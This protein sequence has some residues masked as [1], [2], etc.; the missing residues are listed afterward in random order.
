MTSTVSS[1][2][3][4]SF[5]SHDDFCRIVCIHLVEVWEPII[6]IPGHRDRPCLTGIAFVRH[7]RGHLH[8]T[9]RDNFRQRDEPSEI[10]F[11]PTCSKATRLLP[12]YSAYIVFVERRQGCTSGSTALQCIMMPRRTAQ[13]GMFSDICNARLSRITTLTQNVSHPRCAIGGIV[14]AQRMDDLDTFLRKLRR[15]K[16]KTS[17]ARNA[18]TLCGKHHRPRYRHHQKRDRGECFDQGE[19]SGAWSGCFYA[20]HGMK[21]LRFGVRTATVVS[22]SNVV[23]IFTIG[24]VA[25]PRTSMVTYGWFS[26]SSVPP[27]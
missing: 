4:P 13:S 11:C 14:V 7:R 6:E 12:I 8:F 15:L 25:V 19:S 3:N 20:S 26:L 21:R 17:F 9:P 5:F 23:L 22:I 18:K 10:T 1:R 24:E 27:T 16:L 2:M